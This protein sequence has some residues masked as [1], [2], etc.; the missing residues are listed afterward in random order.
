M[1]QEAAD[2]GAQSDHHG[3]ESQGV[4][5]SELDGLEHLVGRHAGG[6]AQGHGGDQQRQKRVQLDYQNQNQKKG[7][8]GYRQE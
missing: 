1:L 6:Q 3:D 5:E 8:R 4:A 2:H 7:D